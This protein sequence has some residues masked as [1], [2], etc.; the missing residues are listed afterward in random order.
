MRKLNRKDFAV[1]IVAFAMALP[2]VLVFN[3]NSETWYLNIMGI[4]YIAYLVYKL[5]NTDIGRKFTMRMEKIE[6]KIFGSISE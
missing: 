3:E 5:Q 6:R 1:L 4:A 2:M